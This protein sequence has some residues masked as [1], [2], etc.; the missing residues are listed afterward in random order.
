[1]SFLSTS[2]NPAVALF[3][4]AL[5]GAGAT[6]ANISGDALRGELIKLYVANVYDDNQALRIHL[7]ERVDFGGQSHWTRLETV[8]VGQGEARSFVVNPWL[9]AKAGA[10]LGRLLIEPRDTATFSA[11]FEVRLVVMALPHTAR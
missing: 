5:A 10:N 6:D 8:E 1:M 7:E 11:S 4:V 3:P 9:T 2:H